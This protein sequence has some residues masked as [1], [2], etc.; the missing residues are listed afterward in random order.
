MESEG[1]GLWIASVIFV[2]ILI[3]L[4]IVLYYQ[5]KIK[6][7]RTFTSQNDNSRHYRQT[8]TTQQPQSSRL[9]DHELLIKIKSMRPYDF[10]KYVAEIFQRMGY[11]T[12]VT[13]RHRD[14]GIDIILSK[15]GVTSYVQCKK[16][17]NQIVGISDVRAFYGAVV[18][19][20]DGGA[21]FFVTTNI[22]SKD[23]LQFAKETRRGNVIKCID[24]KR[25]VSCVRLVEQKMPPIPIP[26]PLDMADKLTPC[27]YCRSG[28]LVKRYSRKNKH[29]FYGCSNFPECRY[30]KSIG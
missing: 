20:L 18:D 21:A 16:H 1:A 7:M 27:P 25:L 4:F 5:R 9:T 26:D 14:G 8:P 23:A 10:E 15:K 30:C 29:S 13:P 11:M 22:F 19:R 17:I 6:Q 24:G 2:W 28:H 12:Q 3:S